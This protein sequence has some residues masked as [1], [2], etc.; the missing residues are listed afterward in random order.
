MT[1]NEKLL[2]YLDKMYVMSAEKNRLEEE[3]F[4]L[5]KEAG[6]ELSP[7]AEGEVVLAAPAGLSGEEKYMTV[8]CVKLAFAR[9]GQPYW[10][11]TG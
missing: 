1:D 6:E 2:E 8:D 10:L 4:N 11:M 3:L 9:D 5:G 7:I